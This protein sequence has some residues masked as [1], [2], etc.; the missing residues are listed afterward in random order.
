MNQDPNQNPERD[1]FWL[2]VGAVIV[3]AIVGVFL[4]KGRET[5]SV[6]NDAYKETQQQ[7][8]RQM[9]NR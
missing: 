9:Q 2:W 1:N 4:L 3:A 5:Q 6:P 7:V 8:E